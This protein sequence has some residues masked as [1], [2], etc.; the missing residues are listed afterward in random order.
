M[1]EFHAFLKA[2]TDVHTVG[3]LPRLSVCLYFCL[4]VSHNLL[5]YCQSRDKLSNYI[6]VFRISGGREELCM[7]NTPS[8]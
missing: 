8:E 3:K 1:N 7:Y 5:Y 6:F 2:F 4:S